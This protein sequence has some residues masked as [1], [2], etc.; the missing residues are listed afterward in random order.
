MEK[1]FDIAISREAKAYE[2]YKAVAEKVT[3]DDV[4]KVF[5]QLAE[6]ELGHRE[7]LE[8]L[9]HDPT[10]IMKFNPPKAD[11]KVAEATE[12]PDP[13]I[14]MKPAEAIALA[15]KKEQEAVEFYR[16]LSAD[17]TDD[18]LK[19]MFDNLANMELNHKARLENVF[20]EIGYPE[21]F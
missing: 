13:T 3:S 18:S 19:A 17:A 1:V 2:F 12:A 8:I 10:K 15:M 16:Q 7:Q 21:V 14:E 5:L 9:L 6:E 4:K 20:V 11:Y